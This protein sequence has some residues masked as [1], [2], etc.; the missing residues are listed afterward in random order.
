[1]KNY[2]LFNRSI[3]ILLF[4]IVMVH[5][6]GQTGLNFQGVARTNNNIILA[7]Q[8]ISLRLSILQGSASGIAE[9]VETRRVT[10]NAQGLFTAV[11]GD[12]GAIST[13][14]NF[15]TINWRNTPKFL[16]I[17]MDP[18]AGTNFITMG[19]TQF[20]YVAYAQFA[21]S[22]DAENITGVVP[23]ARGGTGANSLSSFKTTL[24]L[25]NV[26][27]TTDLSKPIS[28]ATQTALDLKLNATDTLKYV[29]QTY[30]DS[31]LIT[32]LKLVD[33]ASMLSN[34]I[35]KDT[36]NLSARI[37]LKANSSDMTSGLLLKENASNK[38][39]AVDL[40]GTSPSDILFPT[41]KAVKDYVAANNSAGG[42]ADGGI[43]TIKLAD[44]AVTDAKINTVSGSKVIGN[45]TGNAVTATL[46]ATATTAGNITATSNT[47]LTTLSNLTSVG[48]ITTGTWSGTAVAIEKGGTGLTSAGTA[49]QVLTSTGSGTLV[50]KSTTPL[51][52][53]G[54]VYQGGIVAYILQADDPGFD[55]TIQKGIIAASSDQGTGIGWYNGSDASSTGATGTAIGT[56]SANTT[57]IITIQGGTPTS[58]AA[59]L[60]RAHNGGGYTDWY[61]PSKDELN[62]LYLNRTAIGGFANDYYWSSTEIFNTLAILKNFGFGNQENL[63]KSYPAN[64]RA[65][66]AF[67]AVKSIEDGG[68][69][70]T[71]QQTAINAIT[72][73]QIS[74]RYLRSDGTNA[75]L[76]TIQIGDVPT[77]NQNTTGNAATAGNITATVNTT[78]TSLSNL[79]TVGTITTGVWSGTAVAVEKGGTG[80]TTA[81]AARTNLGLEIGTNVQAPL[82]AG[83]DYLAP[84][85]SAASLTN[86]PTLNQNTTG[87]AATA[88]TA[89]NITATTNTTLI[90][91]SNLATVGT[92][93]SGVWSG[94]AVAIAK[95]GTGLTSAGNN[96]Q[97]LT[98]TGSGT[99]TWTTIDA[100]TLSG[101]TL[102]STITGS[103]LTSVGTIASLTTGAIT[104]S[105]KVIVG[106]SSAA[107]AS[108]VLEASSTTQG[109]LPP[110]MTKAQ[111]DAIISPAAGLTIWNTTY[112]QLEVYNG[113]LWVNMNGTSDQV[114]T[115]GQYFQGG[116]VA[117]ILVSGDPGYDANT[118]HGLIAATSDQS[119]GIQWSN[120]SFT[121]TGATGP[122]IGTGLSNTN[123][124]ISSQG[125]TATSYAAGLARAYKGGGYTDWYL[126]SKN[127]LA[128]LYAMKLLGFGGFADSH[129]WSST[130]YAIGAAWGQHFTNGSQYGISENDAYYVR[131]VRAF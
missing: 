49:G 90:S 3:F 11:I 5:G 131:A 78:L 123:T 36:L 94:T 79:A 10:T 13:L 103:S 39:T 69:G 114:P 102:N 75:T 40:G 29:K 33:T 74:G 89:G 18:T 53:I 108:A 63:G 106:A 51:L 60:A 85:G 122:A 116:I 32:K 2:R 118:Q 130:V 6:Y 117:Y 20:Q 47:T 57:A 93:T 59:G 107:S 30:A 71:T 68:T 55:A 61:L 66:R 34:R 111:R 73:T 23:V 31:A 22:V 80:A 70:A 109:F 126:P 84:T 98:S 7:S 115:I 82:V 83:T 64:V 127:E 88:T 24:A 105:G 62:K 92:I 72:G 121:T 27:N 99:L 65:I 19:T 104:N 101:T 15:T 35:G 25:N 91:L 86:F 112:V 43:T 120:G 8:P 87:N 100:S 1:M 41:Q 95:G 46:A 14:G 67:S 37:N 48:T 125:P 50:W 52:S 54:D 12:T 45:I 97:V 9:Y 113:S 28:T 124:I 38:S 128:K 56:G 21:N 110:R 26:N 77:L 129:Y 96:G 58:Y 81:S 119:T 4:L 16:K 42:V 17:E 44:G 76:S